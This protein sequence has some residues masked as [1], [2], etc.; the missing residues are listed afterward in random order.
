MRK[1]TRG[2]LEVLVNDIKKIMIATSKRLKNQDKFF[3]N[4]ETKMH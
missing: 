3:T 4:K 1:K 2:I